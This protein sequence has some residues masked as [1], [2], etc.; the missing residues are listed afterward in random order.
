[1]SNQ[2][3]IKCEDMIKVLGLG[4]LSKEKQYE[5]IEEMSEIIS[6]RVLLKVM[7]KISK[8]DAIKVNKMIESNDLSG[9]DE[10][11]DSKVPDF[12]NILQ[13]ELNIFKEEMIKVVNA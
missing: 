8:D 4:G 1:M 6:D 12:S 5:I 11:L 7:D 13:E 2:I 9:V 3:L 10:F